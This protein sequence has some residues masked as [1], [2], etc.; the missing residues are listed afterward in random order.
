MTAILGCSDGEVVWIGGD[1]AASNLDWALINICERKVFHVDEMLIGVSG[2]NIVGQIIQWGLATLLEPRDPKQLRG[3]EYM[4]MSFIPALKKLLKQN[5]ETMKND[6]T[7]TGLTIGYRGRLYIMDSYFNVNA[8]RVQ[9]SRDGAGGDLAFGAFLAY[10]QT[11]KSIPDA[12]MLG[13]AVAGA[14]NM[15]VDP[16]YYV[17]RTDTGKET[18][19]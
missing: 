19:S 11:G 8:P 10:R 1:S 13:L 7:G 3:I 5:D 2:R 16:P 9:V 12:M 17:L 15:T 14:H 4:N 18:D 6:H